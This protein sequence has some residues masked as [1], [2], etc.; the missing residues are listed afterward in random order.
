[1]NLLWKALCSFH[2]ASPR[3]LKGWETKQ[4]DMIKHYRY[5]LKP[6]TK[7]TNIQTYTPNITLGYEQSGSVIGLQLDTRCCWKVS[8]VG[9]DNSRAEDG[10]SEEYSWLEQ[11]LFELGLLEFCT[12]HV[13][14]K[15]EEEEANDAVMCSCQANTQRTENKALFSFATVNI[16]IIYED[17]IGRDK[18]NVRVCGVSPICNSKVIN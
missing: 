17:K 10:D 18:L 11:S 9:E 3:S 8:Q 2:S 7:Q 1:M 4:D 12:F 6:L 15:K 14:D 16:H 13:L 5:S